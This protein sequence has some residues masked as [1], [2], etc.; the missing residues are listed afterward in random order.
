[1]MFFQFMGKDYR[2]SDLPCNRQSDFYLHDNCDMQ[3]FGDRLKARRNKLGLKQKELAKASGVSQTTI[4]DI[5]RG[6]NEGSTEMASLAKALRCRVEWLASGELPEE[7]EP[8]VPTF[9]RYSTLSQKERE[10]IDVLRALDDEDQDDI[11]RQMIK[12]MKAK[13]LD[14]LKQVIPTPH[15]DGGTDGAVA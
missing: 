8:P 12:A 13:E 9:D 1:M 2:K 6:R 4:S 7:A 5:E 14:R 11:A 15:N 3:T 10:F